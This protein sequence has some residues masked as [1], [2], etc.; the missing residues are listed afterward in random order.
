MRLKDAAVK[1]H[2]CLGGGVKVE[3]AGTMGGENG[4]G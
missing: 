1:L 4:V 2:R 3:W